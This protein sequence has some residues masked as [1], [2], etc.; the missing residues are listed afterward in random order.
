[1]SKFSPSVD[2]HADFD[3]VEVD[4]DGDLET[5]LM[6]QL[7]SFQLSIFYFVPRGAPAPRGAG[8]SPACIGHAA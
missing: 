6:G 3:V 5:V 7:K 1:M 8:R 2:L 4:E